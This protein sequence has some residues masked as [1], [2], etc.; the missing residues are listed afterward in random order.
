MAVPETGNDGLSGAVN[1]P[2]IGGNLHVAAAADRG[3]DAVGGDDD[4][5]VERHGVRRRVDLAAHESEGLRVGR[6]ADAG[7]RRNKAMEKRGAQQISNHAEPS[8][9]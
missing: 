6:S 1:D 8:V 3:N 5:I 9:G 7:G 2:R 4:R